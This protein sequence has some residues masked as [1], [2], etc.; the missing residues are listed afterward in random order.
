MRKCPECEAEASMYRATVY[1]CPKCG[2][3][4]NAEELFRLLER[5]GVKR[6]IIGKVRSDVVAK[7]I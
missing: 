5:I 7:E 3:I 1:V 4:I 2:S 6:K